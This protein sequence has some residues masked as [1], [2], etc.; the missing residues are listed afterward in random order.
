MARE[1]PRTFGFAFSPAFIVGLAVVAVLVWSSVATAAVKYPDFSSTDGLTL[2]GDAAQEG[3]VLRLAELESEA[4]SAFTDKRVINPEKSFKTNFR[5]RLH[6]ASSQAADGMAFVVQ[7]ND[8][9]ALGE[10]GGSLGYGGIDPSLVVEIDIFH[11][12]PNDPFGDHIAVMDGGDSTAH[13]ESATP[14]FD[15]HDDPRKVWVKYAAG[16]ERL[17]VWVAKGTQRPN[18]PRI[19]V[20]H[21]LTEVFAEKAYAGFTAGTGSEFMSHDVRS[22]KL[23]KG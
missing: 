8:P 4:G 2:N 7:P 9:A 6:D 23:K 14:N 21:P 18:N 16:S 11:N 5:F 20:E 13:I 17:K 1:Q 12:D 15:L 10:G 3:D 19:N 22:W